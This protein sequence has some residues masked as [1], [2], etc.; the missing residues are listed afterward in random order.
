MLTDTEH[1]AII[2]ALMDEY[3]AWNVYTQ[4]IQDLGPIRPFTH[5]REAEARHAAALQAL[6]QKYGLPVPPN[7]PDSAIPHFSHPLEACQAAVKAELENSALYERL[8]D[9]TRRDD[10]LRVFRNLRDASEQRH[11]PAFRRCLARYSGR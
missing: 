7:K 6:L 4:V 11:L 2:E 8:L 5:I 10:I 9:S 1:A 3:H